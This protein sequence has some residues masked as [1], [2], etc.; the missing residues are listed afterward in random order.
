M[1]VCLYRTVFAALLWY[2]F[3][4]YSVVS[5]GTGTTCRTD[6]IFCTTINRLFL[7][8]GIGLCICCGLAGGTL[9]RGIPGERAGGI[10]LCCCQLVVSGSSP[11]HCYFV[12]N[13][14][15]A[16]LWDVALKE[17]QRDRAPSITGRESSPA[18]RGERAS[19]HHG[20]REHHRERESHLPSITGR[21]REPPSITGR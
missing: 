14:Q 6:I 17:T 4:S 2:W 21:E 8:K 9:G 11:P 19:Q 20:E 16:L 10:L 12:I 7:K 5:F 3:W 1:Y 15:V 13:N 18:S